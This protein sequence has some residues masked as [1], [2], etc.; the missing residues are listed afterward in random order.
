MSPKVRWRLKKARDGSFYFTVSS[1][2]NREP[3]TTSEMYTRKE[4]AV[5]GAEAAGCLPGEL[6]DD[7]KEEG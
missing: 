7:T 6:V 5:A 2:G 4:S 3:L 1:E